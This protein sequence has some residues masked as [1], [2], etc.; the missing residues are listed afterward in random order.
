MNSLVVEKVDILKEIKTIQSNK[1]IRSKLI[2]D[3][4]DI[5]AEFVLTSFNNSIEQSAFP[6][7][8]KLENIKS[9]QE[10]LKKLKRLFTYRTIFYQIFLKY[11]RSSCL[12]K[13]LN[14]LNHFYQN[15]SVD[16]EKDSVPNIVFYQC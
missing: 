9:V 11:T 7:R 2:K 12:N 1:D 13:C 6:S 3:N 16:S 8:L 4:A 15:I 14:I 5:F 10:K